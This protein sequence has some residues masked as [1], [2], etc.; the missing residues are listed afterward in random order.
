MSVILPGSSPTH[1]GAAQP[2]H[3]LVTMSLYAQYNRMQLFCC[4]GAS[5]LHAVRCEVRLSGGLQIG[6]YARPPGILPLLKRLWREIQR[7]QK[8][9]SVTTICQHQ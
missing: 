4:L 8:C 5:V 1:C 7:V 2:E 3:E 6:H 9:A